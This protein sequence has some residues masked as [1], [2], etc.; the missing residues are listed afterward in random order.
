[1]GT[2][3]PRRL[4]FACAAVAS[5][6]SWSAA[7]WGFSGGITTNQ[8]ANAALGCNNCPNGGAHTS[9]E[10]RTPTATPTGPTPTLT[11][12]ETP[13][14]TGT[15]TATATVTPTESATTS[16]TPSPTPP[17]GICDP[18]PRAGCLTPGKSSLK[19]VDHSDD[20]KDSVRFQWSKGPQV[21]FADFPDPVST[22]NYALCVYENAALI[23]QV[24][25]PRGGT[26][27]V[28][29]CW[30]VKGAPP[31]QKGYLYKDKPATPSG[32]QLLKLQKGAGK[33]KLLAKGK[34]VHLSDPAA[35]PVMGG[36]VAVQVAN[37]VNAN[38]WGD[39]YTGGEI[40]LDDGVKLR[41]KA[42]Q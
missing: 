39:T 36:T 10:T 12:T 14:A 31:N 16:P 41:A 4:G 19:I 20:A 40:L 6:L 35:L 15:E 38:C 17:R 27:D 13:T 34:G 2:R 18:A 21:A 9:T 25:A 1:M 29:P 30:A 32:M 37:D 8:F 3:A 42:V 33:S 11:S 28:K 5:P 7:A 22:A 24:D 26:C 23:M